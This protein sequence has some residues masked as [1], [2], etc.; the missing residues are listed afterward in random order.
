MATGGVS[1]T[2]RFLSFPEIHTGPERTGSEQRRNPASRF[3][4]SLGT[5][6]NPART[7]NPCCCDRYA[8]QNSEPG[9]SIRNEKNQTQPCIPQLGPGL[10]VMTPELEDP[11]HR[12]RPGY[13]KHW[14]R[15]ERGLGCLV[16]DKYPDRDGNQWVN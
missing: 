16:E 6:G 11:E 3:D 8:P 12:N 5:Q 4:H 7:H 9:P 14:H 13:D 15:P 10:R 2:L 1:V